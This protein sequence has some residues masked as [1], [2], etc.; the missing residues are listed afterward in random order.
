MLSSLF[1]PPSVKP[2]VLVILGKGGVGKTTISLLLGLALS[3]NYCVRIVSLDPA[4]HLAS[5]I[6]QDILKGEV[7][8]STSL[9]IAQIDL[10]VE[11][12]RYTSKYAEWIEEL[13]PSL[14]IFGIESAVDVV[15]NTPG[16]EEEVFLKVLGEVYAKSYEDYIVL[17]T[18]PT[19]ITL[20][21][22]YLPALYLTWLEK[23]IEIR[24][25]IVALRYSIA[26]A[27]GRA[28]E[29][30]DRALEKLYSLK[31]EYSNLWS[32]LRNDSK[33]SYVIVTSPE[34]LPMYEL[35]ESFKFL[36]EKLGVKPRVFFMNRY[37]PED[38]AREM[39]VGDVQEQYLHEL[40]S[41]GI[42]VVI[43]EYL[44]RPTKSVVDV[45]KLLERVRVV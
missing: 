25:R 21:T 40:K 32:M 14:R 45:I 20:R 4:K 39:G 38:L 9:R 22:L 30:K 16:V 6:G 3:G 28:R 23:L 1:P 36:T 35:K 8:L 37:L 43:V 10:E 15:K 19:G 7:E 18:P 17:D 12:K 27:L 33:T 11:V 44:G 26:R 41:T 31:E 5:Y 42:P 34:P 24:E 13:L 2:H 29:V